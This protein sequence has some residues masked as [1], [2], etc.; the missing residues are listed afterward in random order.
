MPIHRGPSAPAR[1]AAAPATAGTALAVLPEFADGMAALPGELGALG[2]RLQS[3]SRGEDWRT[4]QR[5]LQQFLDKYLR[6]FAAS[7]EAGGAQAESDQLRE[8]LRQALGVALA[9]L[10]QP[11]P[12]LADES[13]ALG[14]ELKQWRPGVELAPLA[15]RVRELCHQVGL[16]AGETAEQQ[17]LLLGLF[18]LL[19]E[20][21]VELL[22]DGSWLH[23]QVAVVR[24]LLAGNPDRQA[25][26]TTRQELR[27]LV[28]QQGLLKQGIVESKEAM[29]TMMVT[30]VERLDGM[31]ESTGQFQDR[32]EA[33]ME[34][35]R[36]S[37]S[38]ADLG[39]RL[40]EVLAD[41]AQLQHQAQRAR[42]QMADAR[43]EVDAAEA[44]IHE[45]EA[46]LRDAGEL[47]RSDP[48]TGALNRR[49]FEELYEREAARVEREGRPLS[50]AVLDLDGFGR[51]N[52][53]HG[54]AGGDA[55]LRH[56]VKTART[57]LRAADT[58][59][60]HGGEEFVLLMPGTPLAEA[61]AVVLRL[62][63]LLAAEP[64]VHEG[65]RIVATF[66][67]GVAVRQLGEDREHLVRRADRALYQA[68]CDGRNRIAV[69]H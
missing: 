68:K 45:L 50:L 22:D 48:L 15:R 56:L 37:R 33:H 63:R 54:H 42:A 28:Y 8:L 11:L 14:S 52:A 60:R 43:A 24:E 49:G 36:G 3:A 31:A 10:L 53:R 23:G 59:C 18:D 25:L 17:T 46:Q 35:I 44:R 41:T 7:L 55:V 64:T 57:G 38:I 5:L 13:S 26:E 34:A 27:E 21:L 62:Q 69:A 51:L 67:G 2:R 66:S 16:H 4:C 61:Q 29:R 39:K 19:L 9:S 12:A 6:E 65:Q 40:H 32:L 58:I 1:D 30:F 47:I 20:N